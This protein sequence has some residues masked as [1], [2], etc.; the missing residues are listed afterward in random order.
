MPNLP[1]REAILRVLNSADEPMH[2]TEIA[3]AIID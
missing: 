1:W 3:Q 2:Y